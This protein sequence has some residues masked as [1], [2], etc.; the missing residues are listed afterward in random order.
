MNVFDV[1][2]EFVKWLCEL[3][4]LCEFVLFSVFIVFDWDISKVCCSVTPADIKK[5]ICIVLSL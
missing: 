1:N 2:C 5:S 4:E 3:C